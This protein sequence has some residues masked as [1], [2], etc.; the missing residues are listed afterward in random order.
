MQGVYLDNA[1]TTRVRPEVFEAM[2]PYFCEQYGNPSSIYDLGQDAADAVSGA[3][4]IIADTIGAKDTEIYFTASG[5]EADN[6]AIKGVA[7][8]AA[9]KGKGRHV[10][11]SAIEHHA[12]LHTCQ[13]LEKEGFEVTYL[14]VDEFGL[15]DPVAFE[16]AIRPDTVLA[17]IM[18]ANNEIGTIQPIAELV[19]IAREHGVLFHTDA[20]QAY[21]HE[22]IRV[23]DL[24]VDLMSASAHKLYGPK[25]VGF[26]YIRKGVRVKNLIDGGQQERGKRAAT[27]NVSGIVGFGK[28]VQL[29]WEQYQCELRV[30]RGRG[31]HPSDGH[32]RGVRVFGLCMHERLPRSEPRSFGDRASSRDRPRVGEDD[33]RQ[34]DDC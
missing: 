1:A 8:A 34:G 14:P 27:E 11:T 24:G 15:V 12:V 31:N 28:A 5:S 29:A 9:E 10:I 13:A 6:W 16:K 30:H 20:V 4:G 23:K 19:R 21:C 25:G 32:A 33:A 26:L 2:R 17:S 3:R 18:Y 22:D 7:R